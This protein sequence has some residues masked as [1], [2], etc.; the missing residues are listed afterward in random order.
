LSFSI[1]IL[2]IFYICQVQNVPRKDVVVPIF[3]QG[4]VYKMS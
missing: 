2:F 3:I 4:I 1:Y